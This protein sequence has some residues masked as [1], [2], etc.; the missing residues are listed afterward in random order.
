MTARSRA[1][2]TDVISEAYRGDHNFVGSTRDANAAGVDLVVAIHHDIRIAQPGSFAY[3][4]PSSTKGKALATSIID[5]I[6]A[7]GRPTRPARLGPGK[8]FASGPVAGRGLY[9]L[10]PTRA[11]AT[12]VE[13]GPIGHET[14]DTPEELRAYGDLVADG[15]LEWAGMTPPAKAPLVHR[16]VALSASRHPDREWIRMAAHRHAFAYVEQDAAGGWTQIYPDDRTTPVDSIDYLVALGW[17]A[18]ELVK[19]VDDGVAITPD[20]GNLTRLRAIDLIADTDVPRRRP[21]S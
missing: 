9:I 2:G 5:T 16:D 15:V 3:H 17:E 4:W 10:E 11:P 14:L 7:A 18:G 6:K 12:L 13:I 20:S 21:W 19:E 8:G 1:A